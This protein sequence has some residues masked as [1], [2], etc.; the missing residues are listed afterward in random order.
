MRVL[1]FAYKSFA[2]KDAQTYNDDPESYPL[3]DLVF[4]GLTALVDP[5][6]EGV[7]DT[8]AT[9]HRAG[10]R[11]FMV[12]GDHP[13]TAEAISRKV[14]I[15]AGKTR[16]EVAVERGVDEDDIPLEDPDVEAVVLS[17]T[18]IR[19]TLT[20]DAAWD[21]VLCK[22][23]ITFARTTPQQKLAICKNLQR[24]GEIVAVTGDGT[25]DAPALKQANCGVAMAITGSAVSRAA[26]PIVLLD[27]NINSLVHGIEEG[28]A[29]LDHLAQSIA[30]TLAHLWPE[31]LPVFLNVAF[32]FPLGL[33]GLV[34]LTVDLVAEQ[35]PAISFAYEP[36][37]GSVM[38]RPPRDPK[39]D[40]LVSRQLLLYSYVI[41]GTGEMLTCMFCF[42][43][44]FLNAGVPISLLAFS[45]S[46]YWQEG[47]PLLHL[48]DGRSLDAQQQLSLY[49]ESV[50][51]WYA[52]L[53]LCQQGH[54]WVCK[55]RF[56]S[57]F[58]HPIF[59]NKITIMGMALAIFVMLAVVFIP[60][61]QAVFF[62]DDLRGP[63][64]PIFLIFW[65]SILAWTEGVKWAARNRPHWRIVK[66]FAW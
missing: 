33:P 64:W 49:Y 10:I 36:A 9:C 41:A 37:E 3:N 58:N 52:T 60:W 39:R 48:P 1:A 62:T 51:A 53:I 34:L 16:R 47:A 59:E 46:T 5:P 28:R 38:S 32:G 27:D 54:V 43:A 4:L 50:S 63:V 11:F 22:R 57:I 55:T 40:R 18:E 7:A 45:S 56:S 20:D 12:T 15:I 8:V 2:A 24:R 30:Y 25:N 26:A 17:G 23:Y 21:R 14:N 44:V 35:A 13:L 61:L 65:V 42:F 6:K 66:W 31:L 19:E 29:L